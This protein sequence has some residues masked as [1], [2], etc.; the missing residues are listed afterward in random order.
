[1][2]EPGTRISLDRLRMLIGEVDE[3]GRSV[4]DDHDIIR[5]A[6]VRQMESQIAEREARARAWTILQTVVLWVGVASVAVLA[7][8][9]AIG[10]A[11]VFY[12]AN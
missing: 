5:S 8:C 12:L 7:L 6:L 2:T 9:A 1:M 11:T 4:R 3:R 10:L